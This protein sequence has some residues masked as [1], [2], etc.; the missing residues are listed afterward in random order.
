M[1]KIGFFLLL[2]P[3]LGLSVYAQNETS[4]E[5][6]LTLSSLTETMNILFPERDKLETDAFDQSEILEMLVGLN[7][8]TIEEFTSII[9]KHLQNMLTAEKEICNDILENYIEGDPESLQI[10]PYYVELGDVERVKNGIFF[11]QSGVIREIFSLEFDAQTVQSF[12]KSEDT[13]ESDDDYK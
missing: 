7:I 13:Y 3:F 9:N 12:S 5:T 2:L 10:T 6:P 11:A 4:N 8:Q 1:K